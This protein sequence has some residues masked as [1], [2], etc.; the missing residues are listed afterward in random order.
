MT[1]SDEMWAEELRVEYLHGYQEG[2]KA[3]CFI[4]PYSREDFEIEI[5]IKEKQIQER[6]RELHRAKAGATP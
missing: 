4:A 5:G 1:K 2:L 6:L 3:A